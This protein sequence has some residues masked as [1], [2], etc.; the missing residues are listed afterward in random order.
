MVTP[1]FAADWFAPLRD[2]AILSCQA[3]AG[4]PLNE[5]S[6]IAATALACLNNGA[7]A[8]RIESPERV[9]A[10]RAIAPDAQII[11]LWKQTY[12]DSSV[13]ITP[14]FHHAAAIAAAGADIIAIDATARPRPGGETLVELIARIHD[15]LDKPVMADLDTITSA[16]GA[17][18]AGADLLGTTLYGYTEATA[19]QTPPGFDLL[20]ALVEHQVDRPILCE[21]GIASPAAARRAIDLGAFAVVIGTAVTGIDLQT[22]AYCKAVAG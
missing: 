18:A 2:R 16:Q 13:Y 4:S 3:P 5:P 9:A 7:A 1:R 6:I 11:G 19:H 20:T 12:P 21:G 15:E 17:I 10:V 14:Q 8:V 22:A